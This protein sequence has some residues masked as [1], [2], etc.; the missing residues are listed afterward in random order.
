[1]SASVKGI[2]RVHYKLNE[3]KSVTKLHEIKSNRSRSMVYNCSFNLD[4]YA[5]YISKLKII[6]KKN[7]QLEK[8]LDTYRKA[9][10]YIPKKWKQAQSNQSN[11]NS[12]KQDEEKDTNSSVSSINSYSSYNSYNSSYFQEKAPKIKNNFEIKNQNI[13][14]KFNKTINIIQFPV[15]N[16]IV[17]H[18]NINNCQN[19]NTNQFNN[20]NKFLMN[21]NLMNYLCNYIPSEQFFDNLT[22]KIQQ[23]SNI[24]M[25]NNEVI[26]VFKQRYLESIEKYI[27][28]NLS[29]YY[30]IKFRHY[31]SYFTNISIE[32]SDLDILIYY[33]NKGLKER[34]S[35]INDIL[36]V[37]NKQIQSN[38]NMSVLP[39]LNASTPIIKLQYDIS[40]LIDERKFKKMK[41]L[42]DNELKLIKFDLSFTESEH[43][44]YQKE[45]VVKFINNSITSYPY[46]K[47]IL[48]VFKRYF[49]NANMNK[50]YTGGLSSFSLFLK[51]YSIAKLHNGGY[52]LGKLF[53]TCLEKYANFDYKNFGINAN[54]D[55]CF[56][57]LYNTIYDDD[58]PKD[59]IILIDPFTGLNVA[60]ASFKVKEI[61]GMYSKALSY[62]RSEAYKYDISQKNQI[63]K[64]NLYKKKEDYDF[65]SKIFEIRSETNV[66]KGF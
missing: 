4:N 55:Q 51:I 12:P 43:E 63:L 64:N 6:N 32:G 14:N 20:F 5:N 62:L 22:K 21:F 26:K 54:S 37:L 61:K 42:N 30:E 53:F 56:F 58:Y 65:I 59:E 57:S 35:F 9:K 18:Q 13:Y 27:S 52:K 19:F 46:I 49:K 7:E 33:K 40:E 2:H 34:G 38:K 31:G 3:I 17:T 8:I 16:P 66:E 28:D 48:L 45:M 29:E 24:T 44:F 47:P 50:V 10:E 11:S 23:F 1:M 41:Y 36:L 60:K 15:S 39:I 25:H